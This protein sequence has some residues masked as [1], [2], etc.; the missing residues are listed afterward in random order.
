MKVTNLGA[1]CCLIETPD[2]RILCDPWF[3]DGIYDGSWY[4][5]PP[6]VPFDEPVDVVWISHL[7]PDHYDPAFLRPYLAK[8][9]A[10]VVIADTNPPHLARMMWR[11]KI[12]VDTLSE[13]VVGET[14][15]HLLPSQVMT[16]DNI[17]SALVVKWRGET[18][19]NM[20]DCGFD[21][22]TV[23][24][25]KALG[26]VS[27][28]LLPY[29]GAGPCPQAFRYQP[30][31]RLEHALAKHDFWLTLFTEW[32]DVL[33][34]ERAM[35]FAGQYV[36][37]GKNAHLNGLR[38]T[39]DATECIREG[40]FVLAANATYDVTTKT[41]SG[42]RVD[43]FDPIELEEYAFSLRDRP[44]A[45]EA[46]PYPTGLQALIEQAAEHAGPPPLEVRLDVGELKCG[47]QGESKNVVQLTVDPRYLAGLL[48][49]KWHWNNAEVGSNLRWWREPDNYLWEFTLWLSSFHV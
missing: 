2:V 11:D 24:R 34:P 8:H 47:L 40:V 20:N 28:A 14:S 37:G 15:L 13:L 7:H 3:T 43:P 49:G 18:V 48:S 46:D 16:V 29:S 38:G 45:W 12:P 10:R 33:E 41:A 23:R 26:P 39:P 17:D 5:W 1:S 4:N 9:P 22:E 27:F 32:I 42:L 6:V 44:M 25:I 19:V 21:T 31:T 36:L 35:P 30:R